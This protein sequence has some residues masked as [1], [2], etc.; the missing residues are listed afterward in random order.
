MDTIHKIKNDIITLINIMDNINDMENNIVQKELTIKYF[1]GE[2]K[3]HESLGDKNSYK[4]IIYELRKEID[5]DIIKIGELKKKCSYTDLTVTLGELCCILSN[6][7]YNHIHGTIN[8]C[9][10]KVK[11]KIGTLF[12]N[13]QKQQPCTNCD[14]LTKKHESSIATIYKLKT[15]LHKYMVNSNTHDN[16]IKDLS[17]KLDQKTVEVNTLTETTDNLQKKNIRLSDKINTLVTLINELNIV[18]ET[19]S[20]QID[21]MSDTNK[22]KEL[23]FINRLT[24]KNIEIDHLSITNDELIRKNYTLEKENKMLL[25]LLKQSSTPTNVSTEV[26]TETQSVPTD[27]VDKI[28]I[29][30]LNISCNYSIYSTDGLTFDYTI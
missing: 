17:D 20:K 30:D 13:E 15:E 7:N 28:E 27:E 12:D 19:N 10:N 23:E 2:I 3:N 22:N 9:V 24:Q 25:E 4:K 1:S 26:V 21:T 14:A 6:I 8:N 16:T 18:I 29:D 11:S 5:T